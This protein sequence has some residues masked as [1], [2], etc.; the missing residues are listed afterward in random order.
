MS[1]QI[2]SS[3]L[4]SRARTVPNAVRAA[5][6]V[7]WQPDPVQLLKFRR[8]PA[9]RPTRRSD[10]Q[11]NFRTFAEGTWD[12]GAEAGTWTLGLTTAF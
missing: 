2:W 6:T 4:F 9:A 3:R 12:V 1:F 11:R 7:P 8:S 10:L 5:E